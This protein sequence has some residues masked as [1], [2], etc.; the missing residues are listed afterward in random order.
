M[1]RVKDE[2]D[3]LPELFISLDDLVKVEWWED[4]D[5]DIQ[6]CHNDTMLSSDVLTVFINTEPDRVQAV[7]GAFN[8]IRSMRPNNIFLVGEIDS[9]SWP[10][11]ALFYPAFMK[12]TIN[13]NPDFICASGE[14]SFLAD[15]LLG[16]MSYSEKGWRNYIVKRLRE[17]NLLE[18]CLV[19]IKARTEEQKKDY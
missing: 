9:Q 4:H 15:A 11:P 16:G 6:P 13:I 12:E 8:N 5:V 10:F 17:R 2:F 1:I 7:R 19:N 3:L 14:K 18:K